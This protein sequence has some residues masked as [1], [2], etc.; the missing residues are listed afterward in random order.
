MF[1][2]K[3]IEFFQKDFGMQKQMMVKMSKYAIKARTK[4]NDFEYLVEFFFFFR[5]LLFWG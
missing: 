5:M 4:V 1:T 3:I 2:L